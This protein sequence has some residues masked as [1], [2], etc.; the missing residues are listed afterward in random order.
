MNI[1]LLFSILKFTRRALSLTPRTFSKTGR[2]LIVLLLCVFVAW[3]VLSSK[4][5]QDQTSSQLSEATPTTIASASAS[6]IYTVHP[7][8]YEVVSVTDGDTFKVNIAGKVET[9]RVVGINTPE[10]VD[11]RRPVECFGK[12]AS[13]KLSSL[14]LGKQVVLEPDAQQGDRDRYGRLLRFVQL[15]ELGDIGLIMIQEGYAHESLYSSTPHIHRDA[16]VQAQTEAQTAKRGMW[17]D[18][19][20]P[21]SE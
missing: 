1:Q 20:C 10:T 17:A 5:Q 4:P 16:Y 6:P 2:M 21:I 13:K 12:E 3:S 9:V 15:D 18:N 8:T 11:P 14:L 19:V 7:P